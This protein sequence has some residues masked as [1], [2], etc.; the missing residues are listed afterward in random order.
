MRKCKSGWHLDDGRGYNRICSACILRIPHPTLKR[1]QRRADG[2]LHRTGE[3]TR[4][5]VL[6]LQEL[7]VPMPMLRQR[8]VNARLFADYKQ[9]ASLLKDDLVWSGDFDN[10]RYEL[11]ELIEQHI[12]EETY[13]V[14]LSKIVQKLISDEN[15]LSI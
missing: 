5:G 15:D 12:K 14:N 2:L 8:R 10:I 1:L 4:R 11:L 7:R 13:P 9:A 3:Q 6:H